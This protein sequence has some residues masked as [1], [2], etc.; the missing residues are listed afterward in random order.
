MS[1]T[2]QNLLHLQ[3]GSVNAFISFQ[4]SSFT[5]HLQ[6]IRRSVTTRLAIHTRFRQI[7]DTLLRYNLSVVWK[8]LS[9]LEMVRNIS[10]QMVVETTMLKARCTLCDIKSCHLAD[11]KQWISP[12]LQRKKTPIS[13]ICRYATVFFVVAIL[14]LV[15]QFS[16]THLLDSITRNT[17]LHTWLPV[18]HLTSNAPIDLNH[19][20][21]SSLIRSCFFFLTNF[22]F[23]YSTNEL[24]WFVLVNLQL[25]CC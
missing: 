5:R 7:F 14:F 21:T 6:R 15:K 1:L 3:L 17:A 8:N 9:R 20:K 18:N 22:N 24:Y 4:A 25:F 19:F 2:K 13:T 23:N 10:L 11:F 12:G 16:Q